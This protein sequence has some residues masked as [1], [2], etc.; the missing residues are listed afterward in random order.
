MPRTAA[1]ALFVL[2]L[3][4]A[5]S[6][7]ADAKYAIKTVPSP[8]P[9][10]LKEPFQNLLSDQA[11][12]LTDAKGSVIG[13][14]WLRKDVPVKPSPNQAKG[15]AAYGDIE[16]TTLLGVVKFDQPVTDYRKQRVKPGV[17]TLRFAMQPQ[18]GDHTGTAPFNEFCLLTPAARDDNPQPL[19]D[20]KELH[21]LSK[22]ASG[23]SHPAV[24]LLFPNE[25][26]QEKPQLEAKENDHW[27]LFAKEEGSAGGKKVPLGIGL[28]LIGH[29]AD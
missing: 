22:R 27:V 14:V 15:A 17:Y 9:K 8:A 29:A 11:I 28:V 24:L 5:P 21:E 13:Q 12:Q 25:K 18:D 20:A 16:E 23:T 1:I 7:G 3:T 19:K 2:I 10:E 4:S 26:P 6:L